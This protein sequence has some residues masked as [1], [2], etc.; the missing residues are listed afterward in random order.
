MMYSVKTDTEIMQCFPVC[1]I[2][3]LSK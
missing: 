3:P 2:F 1:N